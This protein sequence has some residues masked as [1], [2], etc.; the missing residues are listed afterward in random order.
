MANDRGEFELGIITEPVSKGLDKAQDMFKKFGAG[1]SSTLGTI[2]DT[3]FDQIPMWGADLK[4][5]LSA[6][7]DTLKDYD[8]ELQRAKSLINATGGVARK[9][10]E[11]I[12]SMAEALQD[13]TTFGIAAGR[14]ASAALLQFRNIRG[15]IFDEAYEGAA[16]LAAVTGS[17]LVSAAERLGRALQDPISG[18]ESL[19]AENI[20]LFEQDKLLIEQMVYSGQVTKAQEYLLKSLADT[21]GGAAKD[22]LNTFSGQTERINNLLSEQWAEIA[23][24]LTPAFKELYPLIEKSAE[25]TTTFAKGMGVLLEKTIAWVKTS[26]PVIQSWF[27][28]A[29]QWLTELSKAAGD[30]F[31]RIAAFGK[32]AWEELPLLLE[33]AKAKLDVIWEQAYQ[34]AYSMWDRLVA[35]V[36]N[37]WNELIADLKDMFSEW[38][39][40]LSNV[41]INIP[42][43]QTIMG[44]DDDEF[45]KLEDSI[46]EASQNA[47]DR[48]PLVKPTGVSDEDIAR[49]DMLKKKADEVTASFGERFNENLADA[50]E[51]IDNLISKASNFKTA[52]FDAVAAAAKPGEAKTSKKDVGDPFLF[53]DQKAGAGGGFEDLLG[54]QKRIQ[55]AALKPPDVLAI[56]EQTAIIEKSSKEQVKAQ[57]ETKKATDEVKGT[58]TAV[59]NLISDTISKIQASYA[60]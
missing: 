9:S 52:I 21:Y 41:V 45:R 29:M 53:D 56:N 36:K 8:R 35:N 48:A 39:G 25:W 19:R 10:A 34:S 57:A 55:S 22:Q 15:D 6:G 30:A 58:L 26:A 13:T 51:I 3:F 60:S 11:D 47:S 54:L 23:N 12:T 46:V 16:D 31:A 50:P 27:D 32:T 33:T 37:M 43:A 14:G 17:D 42:G 44:L 24:A 28:A 40:F 5:G 7:F 49:L 4:S 38:V 2:K 20:L 59:G 18:V 1:V